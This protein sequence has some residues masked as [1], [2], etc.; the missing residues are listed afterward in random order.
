MTIPIAYSPGTYGTYLQWCLTSLMNTDDLIS[1]F[2]DTGSSHNLH[3]HNIGHW[4][5]VDRFDEFVNAAPTAQFA[6]FHPKI[7][8]YESGSERLSKVCEIVSHMI[9]IYPEHDSVLLTINN[10]FTKIWHNQW[11]SF[12]ISSIAKDTIYPNW[13]VDPD[14]ELQDIPRWILREFLSLYLMPAWFDQVE[15]YHPEHWQHPKCCV[16]GVREL[17]DNFEKTLE[18][19]SEFCHL[20]YKRPIQHLLPFHEQNIQKQQY[21]KHD[22]ECHDVIKAVTHNKDLCWQPLSLPSE[23]WIQWKL[24]QLGYDIR[25]HGLDTFPTNSIQLKQLLYKI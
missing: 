1:P 8:K 12:Q 14:T 23:A 3:I 13:P 10:C 2:T 15:W 25:C 21:L 4:L 22:A 19:I 6:R 24:K 7:K 9:Y 17:L 18:K 11:D 20:T 16:I 5:E